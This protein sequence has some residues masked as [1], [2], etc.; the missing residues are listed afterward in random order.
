MNKNVAAA[1]IIFAS[2]ISSLEILEITRKKEINR[3]QDTRTIAKF[4]IMIIYLVSGSVKSCAVNILNSCST[5][6]LVIELNKSRIDHLSKGTFCLLLPLNAN[7]QITEIRD[8]I[9]ITIPI[10]H[11]CLKS[12]KFYSNVDSI[13]PGPGQLRLGS[14]NFTDFFFKKS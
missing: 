1:V 2:V 5:Q 8:E 3:V 14:G 7:W 12:I 11:Y 4:I 9:L 13:K 6:T 10:L